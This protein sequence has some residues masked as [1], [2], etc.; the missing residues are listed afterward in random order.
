MRPVWIIWLRKVLLFTFRPAMPIGFDRMQ[1]KIV[2]VAG[3][4]PVV[5]A[6]IA[7]PGG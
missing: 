1:A 6:A 5:Y 4:G 2:P 7:A 3:I